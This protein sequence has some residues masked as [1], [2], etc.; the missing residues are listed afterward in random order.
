MAGPNDPVSKPDVKQADMI[1]VDLGTK[2]SKQV[3]RLRKGQGRLMD[4]VKQCL[5]E[6]RASGKI[7]GTVQPVIFIVEEEAMSFNFMRMMRE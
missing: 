4:K 1:V 5:E 6:L 3:K 7:S 2:T